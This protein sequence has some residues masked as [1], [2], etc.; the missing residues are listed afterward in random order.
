MEHGSSLL[1]M[2]LHRKCRMAYSIIE[3]NFGNKEKLMEL[4]VSQNPK[5]RKK[6]VQNAFCWVG[7]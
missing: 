6:T 5:N 2:V 4:K 3:F 7:R 1:S